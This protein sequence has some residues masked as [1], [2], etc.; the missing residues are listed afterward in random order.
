MVHVSVGTANAA[1]A[2][3]NAARD[4]MPL[5]F[6]AGRTPLTESGRHGAYLFANPAACLTPRPCTVWRY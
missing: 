2:I 1:C 5:V 3:M 4:N 6:L